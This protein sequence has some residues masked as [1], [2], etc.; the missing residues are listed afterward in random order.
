MYADTSS[1][2]PQRKHERGID[3]RRAIGLT[4]ASGCNPGATHAKA[5][6]VRLG[7]HPCAPFYDSAFVP[8]LLAQTHTS[9]TS[10][11]AISANFVSVK[12][13]RQQ[14][15]RE[16]TYAVGRAGYARALAPPSA[17]VMPPTAT[18]VS[19]R[20]CHPGIGCKGRL[21]LVE[22]GGRW[23][24]RRGAGRRAPLESRA[25]ET[26]SAGDHGDQ[27]LESFSKP[28]ECP[29]HAPR[30]PAL[31]RRA[32][33]ES[34]TVRWAQRDS[35]PIHRCRPALPPPPSTRPGLRRQRA[36]GT[37]PAGAALTTRRHPREP[38]APFSPADVGLV[39]PHDNPEQPMEDAS[40]TTTHQSRAPP[41]SVASCS[42]F[43]PAPRHRPPPSGSWVRGI[44]RKCSSGGWRRLLDLSPF[45]Q[46][47]HEGTS[48]DG[49]VHL[50][51][52]TCLEQR[53]S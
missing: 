31:R 28:T 26:I 35:A 48:D 20:V 33:T 39:P 7:L 45:Y 3:S 37:Q 49:G 17:A 44:L 9:A 21:P 8:P 1:S 13:S 50:V 40:G 29:L 24:Q 22:E 19:T 4:R 32:A 46:R 41:S 52:I 34:N 18:R 53:G 15:A 14:S 10:A 11:A 23:H 6:V 38:L 2:L 25:R 47:T 51:V 5:P 12:T 30:P 42:A 36:M 43:A 16:P 27:H